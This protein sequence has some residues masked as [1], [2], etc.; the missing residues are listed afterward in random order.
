AVGTPIGPLQLVLAAN[1]SFSDPNTLPLASS[2]PAPLIPDYNQGRANARNLSDLSR[3]LYAKLGYSGGGVVEDFTLV[4]SHSG[5]K[6][7]GDF[8]RWAQ[9]TTDRSGKLGTIVA[10]SQ[11]TV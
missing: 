5:F 3:S 4:F 10:Q 1:G 6:R 2:S 8:A 7:G 9:L 11:N